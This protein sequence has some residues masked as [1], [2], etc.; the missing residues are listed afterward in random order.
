M[1]WC[2]QNIKSFGLSWCYKE[3]VYGLRF[4]SSVYIHLYDEYHVYIRCLYKAFI[5]YVSLSS[6]ILYPQESTTRLFDS[7]M[8]LEVSEVLLKEAPQRG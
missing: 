6:P 5:A 3:H 2:S 7:L 1:A 4:C 8:F